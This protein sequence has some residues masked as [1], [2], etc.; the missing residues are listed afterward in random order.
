MSIGTVLEYFPLRGFG[1][2]LDSQTGRTLPVYANDVL[3][4]KG[5]CLKKGNEVELDLETA[6]RRLGS[7][8]PLF[9]STM[10][11]QSTRK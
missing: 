3:L 5:D 7:E 8:R 1:S 10:R 11:S 2:I 9:C 4:I 6:Q